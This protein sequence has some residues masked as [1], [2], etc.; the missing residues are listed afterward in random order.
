MRQ[1]EKK[2]VE[3]RYGSSPV[4]FGSSVHRGRPV[5]DRA[6]STIE[7]QAQPPPSEMRPYLT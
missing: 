3:K 6:P 1:I 5:L 4:K 7:Q 2:E